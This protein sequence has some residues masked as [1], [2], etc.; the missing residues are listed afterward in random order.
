MEVEAFTLTSESETRTSVVVLFLTDDCALWFVVLL[1]SHGVTWRDGSNFKAGNA[2]NY[3]ETQ[4]ALL[5][6]QT[7]LL[8]VGH[9]NRKTHRYQ[10][11]AESRTGGA[12]WGRTYRRPEL[13]NIGC[14]QSMISHTEADGR[15]FLYYVAPRGLLLDLSLVC[16][17]FSFR[18]FCSSAW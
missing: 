14:Q 18:D 2:D 15:H 10:M 17:V 12:T 13:I 8:N 1:C 6:D 4:I 5:S 9:G 7:T 3:G 16:P 11:F